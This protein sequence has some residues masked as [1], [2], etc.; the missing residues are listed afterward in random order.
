MLKPNSIRDIVVRANPYLS[1]DPE[2]LHV[3]LEGGEIACTGAKSLSFEY[4]Y[5]L[6]IIVQDYPHH[7]NQIIIPVLAYLRKNQPELFENPE[8]SGDVIQ[9]EAEILS[10]DAIDLSLKVNLTE[11]VIVKDDRE[12]FEAYHVGEGEHPY[13]PSQDITLDLYDRKGGEHLGQTTMPAW[14]PYGE[15]V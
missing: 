4:R 1:Q 5:V 14:I 2:K 12:N 15:P 7:A 9:F 13:Y 11:R 6:N 8:K 10:V 3:F